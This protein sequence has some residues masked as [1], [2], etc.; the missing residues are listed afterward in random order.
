VKVQFHYNTNWP[1]FN[2][3]VY[4]GKYPMF[5]YSWYAD[6]PDPHSFLHLLFHSASPNNLARFRDP[7]LDPLLVRAEG[8]LDYMKRVALYKQAERLIAEQAPL[9][10]LYFY[11]YE[12]AF[13]AYVRGVQVSALGDPY[14][15]MRSV[16][17]D[18][19]AGPAALRAARP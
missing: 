4:A 14:V 8:E 16:W 17:L 12:R 2:A 7:Q 6:T 19:A 1:D 3:A 9:I 18:R 10:V 15:P 13:Q 5:R 11:T